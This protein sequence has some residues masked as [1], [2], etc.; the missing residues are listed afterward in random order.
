MRWFPKS[1][2][3]STSLALVVLSLFP[4]PTHSQSAE[5]AHPGF[6]EKGIPGAAV[7]ESFGPTPRTKNGHPDLSG[8]Y[9]PR[10]PQGRTI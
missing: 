6:G 8:I 4:A 5:V 10:V 1:L 7:T 3:L 9:F 2:I